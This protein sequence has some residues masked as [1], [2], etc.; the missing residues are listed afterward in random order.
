[1]RLGVAIVT[2]GLLVGAART[3][4]LPLRLPRTPHMGLACDTATVLHC[5]RVGLAVWVKQQ[6]S[7]VTARVDGRTVVLSTKPGTGVYSPGLFWQGFFRDPH[8]QAWADASRSIFVRIS[9]TKPTGQR[10]TTRVLVYV[11]EGYG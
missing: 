5:I 9:V 11:S 3:D 4:S 10:L 7:A 6:A 8:A 1:M 2:A